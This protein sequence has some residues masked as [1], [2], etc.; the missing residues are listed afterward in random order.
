MSLQ[1]LPDRFGLMDAVIVEHDVN[2]SV[3]FPKLRCERGQELANQDVVLAWPQ[4][5]IDLPSPR[6][7]GPGQVVL[8]ILARGRDFDLGAL[9]HPLITDLGE[10][11][12]V[13]FVSKENQLGGP[14]LLDDLTNP[15]Q[16]PEALWIIIAGLE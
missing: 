11:L 10:Q 9:E 13:E 8:L 7:E 15:R 2:P 6:V 5:I 14:P 3:A 12:D 16:A 4:D 1:P